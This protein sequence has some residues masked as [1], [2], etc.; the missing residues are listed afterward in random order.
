MATQ[1]TTAN[2]QS[3]GGWKKFLRE[4]KMELKK[5]TW[6]TRQQLMAYSGVVFVAVVVVSIMIWF[7]DTIFAFLFRAFLKG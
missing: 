5:V 2:V 6:P 3:V 4:V 1:D 7:F